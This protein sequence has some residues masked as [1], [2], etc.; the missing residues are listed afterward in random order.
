MS[1][2][3]LMRADLEFSR[4]FHALVTG[5]PCDGSLSEAIAQYEALLAAEAMRGFRIESRAEPVRGGA[6][7]SRA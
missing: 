5:G 7:I 6:S 2:A 4:A 3:D 1:Y